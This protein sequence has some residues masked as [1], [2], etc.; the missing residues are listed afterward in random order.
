MSDYHV[1]VL[2]QET[3]Q[4]L[5]VRDGGLYIDATVGGG[6]HTAEI[7]RRGGRVLGIDTDEDALSHV[8]KRFGTE[9]RLRLVRGNFKDIRKIA[10]LNGFEKVHGILF[11]LG[12]SSHQLDTPE[13]GFS[14]QYDAPLDMRMDPTLNVTAK[15][16]VNGL[17]R[18]ELY[19]LFTKYSEEPWA[20]AISNNIVRVRKIK[21]I[22]TTKELAGI[23]EKTV[24]RTNDDIHPATRVFQALRIAVNDELYTLERVL[25]EAFELLTNQGRLCVISFH[26]LEDRIVKDYFSLLE[27]ENRGHLLT[28]KPITATLEEITR[29]KRARSAKLRAITKII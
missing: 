4:Y 25:P 27:K 6:G 15:D 24:K 14:F 23:I 1:P 29:N 20:S 8:K 9:D 2:L 7:L 5:D 10:H 19:A 11:D 18:K 16:L 3:L 21:P 22:E 17:G 28:E 13:R 26:S 12:V